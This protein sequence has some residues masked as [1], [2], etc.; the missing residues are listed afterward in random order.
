MPSHVAKKTPK[1]TTE[2]MMLYCMVESKSCVK[3]LKSRII[4]LK[5]KLSTWFASGT[6]FGVG[7]QE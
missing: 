6:G 7:I 1:K 2:D 5:K 4:S 3:N